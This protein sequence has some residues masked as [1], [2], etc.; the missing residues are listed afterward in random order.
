VRFKIDENLPPELADL[1]SAEGHDVASVLRRNSA[2][3]PTPRLL[4]TAGRKK[5]RLPHS[6]WVSRTSAAILPRVIQGSW[7][8]DSDNTTNL[9]FSPC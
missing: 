9:T 3:P 8:F 2:A 7:F 1:L 4:S 5:G 6:M